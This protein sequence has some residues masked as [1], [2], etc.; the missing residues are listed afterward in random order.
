M[1][2]TLE[3]HRLFLARFPVTALGFIQFG[4]R[5][6]SCGMLTKPLGFPQYNEEEAE[7]DKEEGEKCL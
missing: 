7:G 5:T 4:M 3:P 1:S 2:V 6:A